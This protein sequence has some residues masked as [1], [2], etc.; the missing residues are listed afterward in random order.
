M[1]MTRRNVF[2]PDEL[3]DKLR[4]YAVELTAKEGTQVSTA[5]ALRRIVERAPEGKERR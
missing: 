3:W 2:L 4:R 5:E 1:A